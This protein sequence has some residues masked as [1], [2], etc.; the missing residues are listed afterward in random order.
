MKQQWPFL[1][2]GLMLCSS[3]NPQTGPSANYAVNSEKTNCRSACSKKASLKLSA[4]TI[5][6]QRMRFLA[7]CGIWVHFDVVAD[8]Q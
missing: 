6:Y 1:F 4:T 5:S 2:L 7:A 3:A 8:A